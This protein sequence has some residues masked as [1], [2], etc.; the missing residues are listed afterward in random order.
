[1]H[2]PRKCCTCRQGRP[3]CEQLLQ[4]A[5]AKGTSPSVSFARAF[6]TER[7]VPAD[8]RLIRTSLFNPLGERQVQQAVGWTPHWVGHLAASFALKCGDLH[9]AKVGMFL[10]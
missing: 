4:K 7:N 8:Q 9:L 3:P 1:M 6:D 5:L 10:A 2:A